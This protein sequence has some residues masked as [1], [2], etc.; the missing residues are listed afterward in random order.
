M[1][2]FTTIFLSAFLATSPVLEA[3][4]LKVNS[5]PA[6]ASASKAG[7]VLKDVTAIDGVKLEYVHEADTL[8]I[9]KVKFGNGIVFPIAK[10]TLS[11]DTK[12]VLQKFADIL[13][14]NP[15]LGILITGHTD[16]TGSLALNQRLSMKRAQTVADFLIEKNVNSTQVKEIK[17]KDYSEP[18]ADNS[19]VAG[20]AANRR[21]EVSLLEPA[22]LSAAKVPADSAKTKPIPASLRKLFD[23]VVGQSK[24][25]NEYGIEIDGLLVDDTKTKSGKDFYDLF[26]SVWMAPPTARNYTITISEKPFR[27]TT[28][29]IV[30]SINENTVYQS[31]LQ[32]RLD[33]IESQSQE[34]IAITYDYLYNYEEIMKQINGDDMSGSG[35]Y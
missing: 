8:R 17:G 31:I 13:K 19:T 14:K 21:T 11:N 26:Y 10:N 27:L 7:N 24:K 3:D 18:V 12:D 28:T 20:R 29:L 22:A 30:V 5:V 2:L 1:C 15:T 33:I 9:V 34:A 4:S 23:D 35:I 25:Q 32:P 6:S 16:N